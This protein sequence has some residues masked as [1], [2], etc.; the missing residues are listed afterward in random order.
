MGKDTTILLNSLKDCK[1]FKRYFEA[2]NQQFV[3][4]ALPELLD[5][6]LKK[7][8]RSKSEVIR[9]ADVHEVYGY[10]I[11]SG[12]RHPDRKILLRLLIAAGADFEDIQNVLKS[13][14][15]PQLYVKNPADCVIIY[16]VCNHMSVTEINLLLYEYEQELI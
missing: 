16:G 11:F 2:H 9:N 13:S 10:Q 8:G 1:S 5:E 3:T 6:I 7:T 14:S 12:V 15:Y 4:A